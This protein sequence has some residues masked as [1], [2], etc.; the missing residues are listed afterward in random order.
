MPADM[1]LFGTADAHA[2]LNAEA[3]AVPDSWCSGCK[4]WCAGHW[5]QRLA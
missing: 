4:L 5:Q 2:E 3:A 1:L